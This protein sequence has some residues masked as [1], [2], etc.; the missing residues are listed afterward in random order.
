MDIDKLD[1]MD[2]IEVAS[3]ISNC[4]KNASKGE[5][6]EIVIVNGLTT[7]MARQ[8]DRRPAYMKYFVPDEWVKN[9]A[10][11][12]NLKDIYVGIRVPRESFLK[13]LDRVEEEKLYGGE[14]EK[15][16]GSEDLVPNTE[17]PQIC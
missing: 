15:E 4:I 6:L 17:A 11:I 10:G 8:N 16:L 2:G 13:Y 3:M 9:Y 12:D 5:E 7:E 1:K 14:T